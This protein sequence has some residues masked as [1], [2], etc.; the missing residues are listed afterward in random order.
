MQF[1]PGQSG[2]PLG[3]KKGS[4]GGRTRALLELDVI[5]SRKRNSV[6]LRDALEVEFRKN[7]VRFFQRFVMPLLP[8][9]AKVAVTGAGVVEWRSLLDVASSR[10]VVVDVA[11]G[12]ETHVAEGEA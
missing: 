9:E 2:N 8:R 4:V 11:D 3:R 5:L 6:L 7:P 1:K 10:E 12:E